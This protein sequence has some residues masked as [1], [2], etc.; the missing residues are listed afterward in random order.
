MRVQ[1]AWLGLALAA[2]AAPADDVGSS[3]ASDQVVD[4]DTAPDTDSDTD[5]ELEP[6]LKHVGN[7]FRVNEGGFGQQH[8]ATLGLQDDGSFFVSF[9][10]NFNN[11]DLVYGASFDSRVN[12]V[13]NEFPISPF[14]IGGSHPQVTS[15]LGGYLVAWDDEQDGFIRMAAY[16]HDGTATGQVVDVALSSA[17]VNGTADI[18]LGPDG[19]VVVV[20]WNDIN[21]PGYFMKVFDRELI[22]STDSI[23]LVEFPEDLG[24]GPAAL[25]VDDNGRV[26]LGWSEKGPKDSKVWVGQFD[27]QGNPI[28]DRILLAESESTGLSRPDVAWWDGD[29]FAVTWRD[30]FRDNFLEWFGSGAWIQLYD[31]AEPLTDATLLDAEGDRPVLELHQDVMY[32]AW[33]E[34]DV[35]RSGV[36]VQAWSLDPPRK[37]TDA[38]RVNGQQQ[39]WQARPFMR[40]IE[41]EGRPVG[42]ITWESDAQDGDRFGVYGRRFEL[43]AE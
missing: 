43:V 39:S 12:P 36:M 33:E 25:D 11:G 3:D 1:T 22:G 16:G 29:R 20:W 30:H 42:V 37:Y 34:P 10:Q 8:H 31:G 17:E 2:C 38:L 28:A 24:S 21:H 13:V 5:V 9:V 7:A 4:T 32:V 23:Q 26:L 35:D 41:F 14:S 27:L 15:H 18:A 40:V 6:R 19:Q